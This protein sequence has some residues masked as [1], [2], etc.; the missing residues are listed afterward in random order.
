MISCSDEYKR[1]TEAENYILD[2]QPFGYA[3]RARAACHKDLLAIGNGWCNY[4]SFTDNIAFVSYQPLPALAMLCS[5]IDV[6]R[7]CFKLTEYCKK[8]VSRGWNADDLFDLNINISCLVFLG[9]DYSAEFRSNGSYPEC[10]PPLGDTKKRADELVSAGIIRRDL[11]NEMFN[12]GLL[13]MLRVWRSER[14]YSTAVAICDDIEKYGMYHTND[15]NVWLHG[16]S[17][18]KR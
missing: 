18:C 8:Y 6:W 16:G 13:D 5:I 12:V 9:K 17:S 3:F 4:M 2:T 11:L 1:R 15:I 14:R 10:N 7:D